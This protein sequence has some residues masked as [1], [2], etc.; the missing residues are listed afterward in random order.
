M[1]GPAL[2]ACTRA[3]RYF[4]CK[5]QSQNYAARVLQPTVC[6]GITSELDTSAMPT[7]LAAHTRVEQEENRKRRNLSNR[8][9][10]GEPRPSGDS[11]PLWM[12]PAVQRTSKIQIEAPPSWI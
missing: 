6:I 7:S 11:E 3:G 1:L 12:G 5:E 4:H 9:A 8:A 2:C 10:R